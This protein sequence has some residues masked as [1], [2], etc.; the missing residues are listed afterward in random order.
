MWGIRKRGCS[1]GCFRGFGSVTTKLQKWIEK[2]G[3]R[4]MHLSM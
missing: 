1:S 2:L 3:I 4:I